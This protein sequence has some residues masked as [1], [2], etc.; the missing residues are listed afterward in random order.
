M[1]AIKAIN[2]RGINETPNANEISIALAEFNSL[3]D[4]ENN[5]E[6]FAWKENTYEFLG[7]F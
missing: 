1:I 6:L 7:K 5:D 2:V 3:I 4:S